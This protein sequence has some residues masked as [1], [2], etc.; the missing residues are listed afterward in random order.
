MH[1]GPAIGRGRLGA[2]RTRGRRGSAARGVRRAP[3]AAPAAPRARR[4]AASSPPLALGGPGR[5]ACPL[6]L[7]RDA[8]W[9]RL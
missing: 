8:G 9:R 4:P 7:Q 1:G 3:T 6:P 5:Y 2:C